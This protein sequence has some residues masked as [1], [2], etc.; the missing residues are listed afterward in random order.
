[1]A[2]GVPRQNL[3]EDESL[4]LHERAPRGGVV[5]IQDGF[6][7]EGSRQPRVLADEPAAQCL[8]G[9][10]PPEGGLKPLEKA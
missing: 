8:K 6:G 4:R 2:V 3:L 10:R 1:M 5:A 9:V 7:A